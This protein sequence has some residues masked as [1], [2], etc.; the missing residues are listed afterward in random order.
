[1]TFYVILSMKSGLLWPIEL[2]GMRGSWGRIRT[3]S[4]L[5]SQKT[6][7]T[8]FGLVKYLFSFLHSETE[9]H[10]LSTILTKIDKILKIEIILEQCLEL[11]SIYHLTRLLFEVFILQFQVVSIIASNEY[12]QISSLFIQRSRYF[13]LC[14][15]VT[16]PVC[17]GVKALGGHIM[18]DTPL[19]REIFSYKKNIR[20]KYLELENIFK[21]KFFD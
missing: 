12:E 6:I 10:S 16:R 1:M 8:I 2:Q 20:F 14:T 11:F 18:G 5:A 4:I 17:S 13:S 21:Y 7:A 3:K 15:T 9:N 19:S